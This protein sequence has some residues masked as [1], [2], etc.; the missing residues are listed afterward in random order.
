[1]AGTGVSSLAFYLY[2]PISQGLYLMPFLYVSIFAYDA[3]YL[4]M[5]YKR[6]RKEK[7]PLLKRF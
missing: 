4:G 3:I 5:V 7:T 2:Q 6:Y 1:M